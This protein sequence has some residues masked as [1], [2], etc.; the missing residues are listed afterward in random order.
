MVFS[1]QSTS[2][3]MCYNVFFKT[4]LKTGEHYETDLYPS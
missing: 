3:S 4:T 1:I 2:K